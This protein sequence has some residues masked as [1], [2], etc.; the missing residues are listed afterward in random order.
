M[1]EEGSVKKDAHA[2]QGNG[3]GRWAREMR[4]FLHP[5]S[6]L[7]KESSFS[8][9][10]VIFSSKQLQ[11]TRGDYS[12]RLNL[13]DASEA[14]LYALLLFGGMLQ[15]DHRANAVTVDEWITFS[16]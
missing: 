14:S 1:G 6:M 8:C 9:P 5:G 2:D 11:Q 10:W 16:G 3:G 13:S 12:T 7:F 4:G 15:V